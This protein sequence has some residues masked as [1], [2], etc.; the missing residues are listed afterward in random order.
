MTG[1]YTYAGYQ[2]DTTTGL[3]YVNARYYNP[4]AGTWMS[5]DPD[6]FSAGDSNLYRYVNNGPTDA[7]DPSGFLKRVLTP[8]PLPT[9][10]DDPSGLQ[11]ALGRN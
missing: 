6:G 8:F 3:Y 7:T 9:I 10:A 1:R 11:S 2:T 4:T 5:E